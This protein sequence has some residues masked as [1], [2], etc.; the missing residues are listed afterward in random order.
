MFKSHQTKSKQRVL[1]KN[2]EDTYGASVF[3][4]DYSAIVSTVKNMSHS[5]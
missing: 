3:V 1:W 5:N 2:K 4:P